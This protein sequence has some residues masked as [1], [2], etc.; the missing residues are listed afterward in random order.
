[1]KK[2]QSRGKER[3]GVL[4]KKPFVGSG[5]RQSKDRT[6]AVCFLCCSNATLW[7]IVSQYAKVLHMS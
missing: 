2:I 1:M 6:V 7:Y 4:G 3:G 5:Q